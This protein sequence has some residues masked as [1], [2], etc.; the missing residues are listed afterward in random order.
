MKQLG[1]EANP[2]LLSQDELHAVDL[3]VNGA[4]R[5]AGI[6]IEHLYISGR[7]WRLHFAARKEKTC[8]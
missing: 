4:R 5:V 1:S 6:R 2:I 3:I 8:E 7:G